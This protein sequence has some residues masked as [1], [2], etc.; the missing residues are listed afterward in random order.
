MN[1]FLAST[2]FQLINTLEAIEHYQ[3]SK[4]IIIV[5]E[6]END[7]AERQIEELLARHDW[8][9]IIHLERNPTRSLY[10]RLVLVLNQV[11][12]L[13]PS[14]EFDYVFYTE[15]PSRR[16]A[17]ILGN[18]SIKNKEVMYDDGT[19]TLKAYEEQLRDNVRVSYSQ[20]KRNLTLNIFGY[21]KPRDFY[22]HEKFELFTLFD[23]K[24]EHFHIETNTYPRLRR[25]ISKQPTIFKTKS[26]RA[27]FIGD[28]ATD[29]GID[30]N[31]YKK[32]LQRLCEQFDEVIYF[33]HRNEKS[34]VRELLKNVPSLHYAEEA[35]GPIEL[36]VCKYDNISA[37]YGYYSTALFTLSRIYPHLSI[38]TRRLEDHEITDKKLVYKLMELVETYLKGDNIKPW[39][40]EFPVQ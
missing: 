29:G 4:N 25:Q 13:N 2:P 8:F 21:K 37:I 36:E 10:P 38:Y 5:R 9:G 14:M 32:S 17:T 7:N 31:E 3:C 27:M 19:W 18:I 12:K 26:S 15:Y 23:L 35:K 33:P 20:L 30:L 16:V 6:Q 34:N 24:A 40:E 11:R 39:Q 28:G 22:I 1:L